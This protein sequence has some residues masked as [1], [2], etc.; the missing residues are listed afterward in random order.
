[1]RASGQAAT[2]LAAFAACLA[3]LVGCGGLS[4]DAVVVRVGNLAFSKAKVDHWTNV[5]KHGGAFG[6]FR[7]APPRGAPRRRAVTLLITSNWL[8]LEA[9]HLGLSPA[10]ATVRQ[11]L[12]EQ[13]QS[14][15]FQRRLRKTGEAIADVKLEVAAELAGEAIRQALARRAARLTQRAL[16]NLYRGHPNLLSGLEVRVTDLIENQPSAAA[17]TA[18]ARR[19]G[20]GR[21][22]VARAHHERVSRTAGFMRT[23]EKVKLVDAIFAARPGV[24]SAP[25]KLNGEWAVF[26]VRKVIPAPAKP[27]SSVRTEAAQLLDVAQ[28]HAIASKFDSE[29]RAR[30]RSRTTCRS[31]Y[32]APGCPQFTGL[33]EPYEDP[34]TKRAHPLL[35]EGLLRD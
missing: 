6:G 31:D 14:A 1:M 30:W 18:L 8:I 13:Q 19:I 32:V 10:E 22:F 28:Q 16:L 17:A 26:V 15:E 25:V 3:T 20:S 35:A 12:N 11:A 7:G 33:L 23:P 29:Y 4:N 24:V 34:F 21:R 27:L 2:L 5:I 9:A